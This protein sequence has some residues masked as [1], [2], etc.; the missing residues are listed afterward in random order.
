MSNE[1]EL[2]EEKT[3]SFAK[4][5]KALKKEKERLED[6]EKKLKKSIEDLF[7]EY[8]LKSFKNDYFSISRVGESESVSIDLKALEKKENK[9]YEELVN[10]YPKITKRKAY[11]RI[12]L[13]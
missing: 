1:L 3:L 10:D 9:L 12:S 6:E 2:F 5:L 13:K 7:N 4:G 11:I 8:D